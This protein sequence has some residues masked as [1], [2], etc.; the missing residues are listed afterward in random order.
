MEKYKTEFKLEVVKS[1]LA[2]EGGAKL[3]ARRWSVPEEKIRTWVS[4]FRLHGINGLRPKRSAYSAQFKMQVLAHQDREQLSSRQVAA[5]YD[6]RNANQ[7]VVWRRNFEAGGMSNIDN[8]NHRHIAMKTKQC[9][10]E[11]ENS[12]DTDS[13]QTLR[14]ENERLRAEVAYLKKLHALTRTKR[15]APLTKRV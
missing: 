15:S 10:P 1:F 12:V 4:R 13:L 8:K 3:L 14:E 7:V 11:P 9:R 6:I 2:G 5:L